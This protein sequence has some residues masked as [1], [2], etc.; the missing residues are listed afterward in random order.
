MRDFTNTYDAFMH[1][2]V[3]KLAEA[4][5]SMYHSEGE[6]CDRLSSAKQEV[7]E[8]FM[9]MKTITPKVETNQS[10]LLVCKDFGDTG[11]DVSLI[12]AK[13]LSVW[14]EKHK[15]KTETI[16]DEMLT[17]MSTDDIMDAAMQQELPTRYAIELCSWD[18][19][20]GWKLAPS[21]IYI[22]GLEF[23]LSRVLW[24]ITFFGVE[25]H[26]VEKAKAD[27][28]A[29]IEE[30]KKNL[31][32]NGKPHGIPF[33]DF[34]KELLGDDYTEDWYPEE[35]QERDRR[36]MAIASYKGNKEAEYLLLML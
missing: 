15:E 36:N 28:D 17:F 30:S 5:A 8:A 18:E 29:S 26:G 12:K 22:Y 34:V 2:D 32:E 19:I 25:P 33:E 21:S 20:L 16:S 9:R 10:I 3:N 27:L 35:E 4:F 14:K 7:N 31:D 24:E 1:C 11:D 23:C 13:D 6:D